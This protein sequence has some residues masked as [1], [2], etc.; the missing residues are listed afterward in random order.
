M[1]SAA[2]ANKV[3]RFVMCSSMARYGT[4]QVPFTEDMDP[5]R[6]IRTASANT[7]PS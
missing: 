5:D 3:R 7:R 2:I 4:N 6:R 1:I